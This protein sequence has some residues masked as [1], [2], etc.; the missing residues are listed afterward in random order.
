MI[1]K[2]LSSGIR[3]FDT[4]PY[5][6]P[7]E[8]I[9]GAA[10]AAQ[11]E[12]PRSSYI[13][14]SKCGRI[15]EA[16]FDYSPT[17][18]RKSV[19]RSCERLGT[20]YLDIV[21]CHDV[22]FVTEDEVMDAVRTL[23]ELRGEGK[24]RY[25][26]ISGYPVDVLGRL[27]L[28]VREVT[29][30]PL[31]VVFGYASYTM[32]STL[33]GEQMQRFREAQVGAVLHGSPLGMGLLREAGP[34]IGSMGDFHPAPRGLRQRCADAAKKVK[35]RGAGRL[36]LLALRWALENWGREGAVLGSA[37]NPLVHGPDGPREVSIGTRFGITVAGGSNVEEVEE[38]VALWK[39]VIGTEERKNL[40][41][42]I[43]DSFKPDW[44]NYA[45]PSPGEDF[46]RL[47]SGHTL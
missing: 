31:D 2:A 18:V 46:V 8:E 45:W 16:E 1:H 42:S 37:V 20:D 13:L 34:P 44:R 32:Q 30:E 15:K 6:G 33:L 22:E 11:S 26:G 35:E 23:R 43:I 29:G 39:E 38:L 9:L 40:A 7:S 28:R 27:A 14:Q 19:A 12:F 36:E 17:W 4:S 3:A 24:L 10:L 5:Y 25:V 47:R 41:K 21:I